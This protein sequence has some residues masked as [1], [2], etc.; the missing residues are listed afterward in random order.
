MLGTLFRFW[1]YKRFVFL[2]PGRVAD[3]GEERAA[4]A[5]LETSA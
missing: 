1:S 5:T 2:D 3:D 4:A